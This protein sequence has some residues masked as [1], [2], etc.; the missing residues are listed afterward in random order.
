MAEL[1]RGGSPLNF[2]PSWLKDKT[3]CGEATSLSSPGLPVLRGRA[4][5]A[6]SR[7]LCGLPW[8]RPK[9]LP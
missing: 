2:L 8:A 1:G 9:V 3:V 5:G 6:S 4:S 7:A